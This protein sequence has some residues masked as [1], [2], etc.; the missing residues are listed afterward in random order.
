L[1][2]KKGDKSQQLQ[3]GD[4]C[5]P[6]KRKGRGERKRRKKTSGSGRRGKGTTQPRK[7]EKKKRFLPDL[8]FT[9]EE[10][11]RKTI[12]G[13]EKRRRDGL[14]SYLLDGEKNSPLPSGGRGKKAKKGKLYS[15]YGRRGIAFSFWGGGEEKGRGLPLTFPQ[16]KKK[17]TPTL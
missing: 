3:G 11:K 7:R 12:W 5:C 6:G 13:G 10:K 17:K 9:G 14:V 1:L 4:F 8:P 15:I 2:Q 16:R